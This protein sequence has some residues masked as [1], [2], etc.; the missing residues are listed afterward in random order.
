MEV[1]YEYK[2]KTSVPKEKAQT[3]DPD[4]IEIPNKLK[5]NLVSFFN[6]EIKRKPSQGKNNILKSKI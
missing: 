4:N 3:I 5:Y 1:G 2:F 6:K